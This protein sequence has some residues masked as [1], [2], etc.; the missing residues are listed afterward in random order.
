MNVGADRFERVAAV[1]A[2]VA[3]IPV[4]YELSVVIVIAGRKRNDLFSDTDQVPGLGS[5]VNI[6]F[7]VVPVKHRADPDRIP[8]RDQ[9]VCSGIVEDA[10]KFGIQ[11]GEHIGTVLFI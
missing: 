9:A 6:A 7:L 4:A 3:H 2:H 10:G 5:E 8:G 1:G 11:H